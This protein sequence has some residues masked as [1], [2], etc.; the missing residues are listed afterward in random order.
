MFN[1][2][3]IYLSIISIGRIYTIINTY[4]SILFQKL[5]ILNTLI[6]IILFIFYIIY[7]YNNYRFKGKISFDKDEKISI[8][9][10]IIL[11]I[12]PIIVMYNFIYCKQL[13]IYS[14][15]YFDRRYNG[16]NLIY[17]KIKL[18]YYY[19]IMDNRLYSS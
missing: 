2:I 5:V 17:F 14:P 15:L 12:F 13:L 1:I 9:T 19:G 3:L 6:S 18:I 8:N 7:N 11:L 10:K 16:L 4:D